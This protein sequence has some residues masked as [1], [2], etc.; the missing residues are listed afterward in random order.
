MG[1]TDQSLRDLSTIKGDLNIL[2]QDVSDIATLINS[3]GMNQIMSSF[4]SFLTS[5][6]VS[7]NQTAA[8][9]SVYEYF[10]LGEFW[11][12]VYNFIDVASNIQAYGRDGNTANGE[13]SDFIYDDTETGTNVRNIYPRAFYF[14]GYQ[15]SESYTDKYVNSKR[16]MVMG[17][18]DLEY[19][20]KM[21]LTRLKLNS[22]LYSGD[23]LKQN[24]TV[25]AQTCLD[26]LQSS[27]INSSVQNALNHVSTIYNA[28]VSNL[29]SYYT[30]MSLHPEYTHVDPQSGAFIQSGVDVI[31][32]ALWVNGTFTGGLQ[33]GLDIFTNDHQNAL[34]FY[35]TIYMAK[36]LALETQIRSYM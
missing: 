1:K 10:Q 36:L 4:K 30:K 3:S 25:I 19:L 34:D 13:Y 27:G 7:G 5:Y 14:L 35:L 29:T 26:L 11:A 12:D 28:R 20:S 18:G 16:Q 17:L 22:V 21:F 23:D 8:S 31:W 9:N 33:D 2:K 32:Q 24:N 6:N 15:G